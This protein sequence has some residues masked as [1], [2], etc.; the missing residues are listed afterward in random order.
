MVSRRFAVIDAETDPFQFGRVPRPFV[1]GYYDGEIYLH[2]DTTEDLVEYIGDIDQIVFAHNGG[3]FDFHFLLDHV[4]DYDELMIV[5][6]RVAKMNIGAAELRDSWLILPVPLRAYEKDDIDYAIMEESE[7]NKPANRAKILAYL[8]SDCVYLYDLIARF[9]E[10]YG[11]NLTQAGSS[12]KQWRKIAPLPMPVTD[13]EFY[14]TF[15]PYY[16]GGR[17]QCFEKG[18]INKQFS[19]FDINSAYPFAM[20]H[21]HPYSSNFASYV[22]FKPAADFYR[23]VCSS[24]GALPFRDIRSGRLDFPDDG[25]IREYT[26]T[27]WEYQA[28]IDTHALSDVRVLESIVF[29]S[30]V[31]FA[32]YVKPLFALRD[33]AK[34][35]GDKAG[36]LLYKLAMNSLYGKFAANPDNYKHYMVCPMSYADQLPTVGWQFAGQFGSRALAEAPLAENER[37]YYNVATGAS[38]TGFV[39]AMLWRA[40]HG[41]KR[42]IYC[43]TDSIACV[44][45]SRDMMLSDALGAWK[46]EGDFDRAGIAGKKLYIFRGVKDAK[47]KREYKMAAKG[48][49]LTKSQLWQVASGKRVV[50]NSQAPTFS[51]RGS[52]SFV[53]RA[54]QLTS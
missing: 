11:L 36:S 37:H 7:R 3:K 34:E 5:N 46:H 54:V 30:H 24:R 33:A 16:Y 6:G 28:A 41:A 12:M 15:S 52:P 1:W 2:F 43:D 40:I 18:I 44:G 48:V 31:D 19:V 22:G 47:G 27:G 35:K 23:I 45:P 53:S 20:L 14:E 9:V 51:V 8:R 10:E 17:V 39:R 4:E 25:E 38:I 42:V 21:R 50:Y 49:R 13:Q 32:E 26:V 29:C